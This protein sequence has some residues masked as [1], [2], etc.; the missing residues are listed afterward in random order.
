MDRRSVVMLAAGAALAPLAAPEG[1]AQED[2][3][4][5]R[6][7]RRFWEEVYIPQD[8]TAF[9]ELVADDVAAQDA[10][11]AG[12]RDAWAQRLRDEWRTVN[13]WATWHLT[14]VEVFGNGRRAAARLAV[15][16]RAYGFDP[17]QAGDVVSLCTI[18][19]G[20]IVGYWGA[21]T[22]HKAT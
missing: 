17:E 2:T 16:Y 11:D 18:K 14:V 22:L 1:R 21:M 9:A 8:L 3:E 5:A 19:A 6:V 10:A 13:T 20:K 4:A 15:R 7:L 12:G